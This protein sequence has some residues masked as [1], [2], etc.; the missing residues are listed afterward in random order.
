MGEINILIERSVK[1]S[2]PLLRAAVALGAEWDLFVTIQRFSKGYHVDEFET[3]EFFGKIEVMMIFYVF[4]HI[5]TL[6]FHLPV[7]IS[8]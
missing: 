1:W 2:G 3:A 5:V 6:L 4:I 7:L 8:R